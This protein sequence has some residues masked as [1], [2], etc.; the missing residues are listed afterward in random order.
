MRSNK[1]TQGASLVAKHRIYTTS[2]ASVYPH[3]IAKAEKKGRTTA[4]VGQIISWL[5]GYRQKED[6]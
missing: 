5:T 6:R 2:F 3:Y 1:G 4:E